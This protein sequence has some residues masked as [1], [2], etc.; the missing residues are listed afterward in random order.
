MAA[1]LVGT[2]RIHAA[3]PFARYA[4]AIKG[5]AACFGGEPIVAGAVTEVFE[6][7]SPVGERVVVTRFPNAQSARSYLTSPAYLA[8]KDLRA[9][10]AEIE[11]RLIEL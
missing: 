9:G 10:A 5:L 2:V 7:A 3:E 4:A 6:G 1:Y 8:A 11:L